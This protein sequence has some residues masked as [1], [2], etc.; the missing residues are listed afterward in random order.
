[1][2]ADLSEERTRE[3]FLAQVP[4]LQ[5]LWD[6]EEETPRSRAHRRGGHARSALLYAMITHPFTDEQIEW[7]MQE[8]KVG[9]NGIGV[10]GVNNRRGEQGSENLFKNHKKK[11]FSLS[12]V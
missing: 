11:Y 12:S 9:A 7:V 6:G 3:L 8:M 10:G 5:R 4:R 2:D 1:M